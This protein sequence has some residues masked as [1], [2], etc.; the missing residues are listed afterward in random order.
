MF[1]NYNS[2]YAARFYHACYMFLPSIFYYSFIVTQLLKL[3][4]VFSTLV[5]I[6]PC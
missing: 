2:L 3:T 4:A 5:L 1:P 6:H